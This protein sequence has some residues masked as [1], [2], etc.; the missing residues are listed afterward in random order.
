[1]IYE[2]REYRFPDEI[3]QQAF[4]QYLQ[5]IAIPALNRAGVEPVGAFLATPPSTSIYLVAPFETLTSWLELTTRATAEPNVSA[6]SSK[7]SADRVAGAYTELR[8][9]ILQSFEAVPQLERP[10]EN[11][12]RVFQLRTYENP[13]VAACRKKVEMFHR[14]EIDIFRRVGL[15]P[16]FFG[17]AVAGPSLPNLT[18]MLSFE[19]STARQDAWSRFIKD[20]AWL[21][22]KAT[23]GYADAELIRNITNIELRP[24][25]GSA[26]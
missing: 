4:S 14:G 7:A 19:S 22:L 2:L 20:P 5:N 9:T 24:L 12:G 21:S 17:V 6:E 11:V 25:V 3:A 8:T 13:S 23:P 26:L 15:A 1:M 10:F 16:V 18:Y